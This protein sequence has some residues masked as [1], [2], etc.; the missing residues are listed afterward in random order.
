[1]GD[2]GYPDGWG[3]GCLRE[4]GTRSEKEG[5]LTWG[6]GAGGGGGTEMGVT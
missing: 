2:G 4:E 1:M 6:W 5:Y 3:G